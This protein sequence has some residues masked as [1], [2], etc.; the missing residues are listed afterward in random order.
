[1]LTSRDIS[2]VTS[3]AHYYTLTRPQITRLHFPGDSDGRITR[4]R[5]QVVLGA[6][7]IHRTHMQVVN[8][9]MGAPAPVYY[10]SEKGIAFLAQ[11]REDAR[12]LTVCTQTPTWQNLYHW[13]QIAETHIVLDQAAARVP[14]LTIADWL[15]EWSVANPEATAPE[16][17]YCLYT[18]LSEPGQPRLLAAPDAGFLL[19]KDTFRKV[20]YLEQDRDSTKNAQRVASQKAKGYAVLFER[21]LQAR[22]FPTTNVEKFSVLM[23]APTAKRREALRA[24]FATMPGA[25]LWKFASQTELT[26]DSFLTDSVWHP[27]SGAPSALLLPA[28]GGAG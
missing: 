28:T 15:S 19:E 13:V 27:C 5:L 21:R 3:V 17:R 2:V 18:L 7:L 1:M 12:Y 22:H 25:S 8:P 4:K 10:P 16:K 9:A 24:A 6:G 11:E 20:F 14:G 23:I 26:A